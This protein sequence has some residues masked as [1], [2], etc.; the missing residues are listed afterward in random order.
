M[1]H[2]SVQRDCDDLSSDGAMNRRTTSR[3]GLAAIVVACLVLIALTWFGTF[4]AV[5]GQQSAAEARVE[6]GVA[7]QATLFAQQVRVSLAEVDEELRTLAHAWESD[8]D[9]FRLQPWRNQFV[10][11]SEISPDVMLADR[12]GR[13]IDGTARD[14]I[15]SDVADQD[16]FRALSRRPLDDGSM[17]VGPST[18]SR[19]MPSWH[20]NLARPLRNRDGSFAG[21]VVAMLQISALGSFYNVGDI[22]SHGLVAVVGMEQGVL[23]FIMGHSRA[24]PGT[25]IADSDMFKAMQSSPA[26]VWVGRTTL[27]GIER[28]HG[29]R[30]IAGQGLGV[31][32]AVDRADAMSATKAWADDA[33]MFAGGITLLLLLLA[34]T[35]IYA[36]RAAR[37]REA[38]LDHERRVL[39]GANAELALAKARADART[40]LLQATF[41]GM[42]DGVAMTDA[43]MQLVAWNDRFPEIASVPKDLLRIGLPMEDILHAQAAAGVFGPVDV[44]AEVAR[45]MDIL[46]S[47]TYPRTIERMAPDGRVVELRRN[48]LPDGGFVTLYSDI[49]AH[50]ESVNALRQANALAAAATKAMSRFVAIVSHEIRT[51]LGA[52]LNSLHL[53]AD[54]EM[55]GSHRVLAETAQRAGEALSALINDILEMSRMEAGQ[56]ALRP[57]AFALRPLIESAME[58]FSAQAAR[59]RMAL[60]LSIARGVPTE[61]YED[62]GRL[63][64]I[65]INLLSNALK[66]ADPGEV[67]VI[68][69]V[70]PNGAEPRLRLAVRDRGPVIP[71]A[72]CIHLFEPFY[73]LQDAKDAASSAGTGLGLTICRHLVA[74]M[75]GEIG[76][77]AWQLGSRDAGNE[78]WLILPIKPMPIGAATVSSRPVAAQPRWL[79]RTRILLVEDILANQMVTATL[80]RR[81]GHQVDVAGNGQEAVGAVATSPYDLVLMDIFMPGMS[82]LEAARQIRALGGPAAS[83]PIVALTANICAEDQAACAAAGMNDMLA[84]P[85]TLR[86]LLDTIARYVWPHR[87]GRL[88]GAREGWPADP[89]IAPVLAPSRLA[90]L[91]ATLPPGTLA[92][93]IETCLADLSDRLASLREASEQRNREGV[94]SATH[95]MAGMAAEYGM[96]SLES[97]LRALMQ[98]DC[99]EATSAA[100]LIDDVAAELRRTA[101]ALQ[102]ALGTELV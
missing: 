29:F 57:G 34:A 67:R 25:S 43:Y 15:G 11:L 54:G 98:S 46:R 99:H 82:G 58:I 62:P 23:R 36:V 77:R 8:P 10:L 17:F 19:L 78:F 66:F 96:A 71:P 7:G 87:S 44:E 14:A 59:C 92:S 60:R 12:R 89:V 13:I 81:E 88:P 20:M 102:E 53:L 63:R 100:P 40:D 97:R 42:S 83:L 64:Q 94:R 90:E 101:A 37:R 70:L 75:G 1:G 4:S 3:F 35:L 48:G 56:L 24:D 95:A 5:H 85:A 30:Q 86:D 74:L 38:A 79:P 28:V 72:S 16:Y 61:L 31:I 39:A 18:T 33:Y 47:G 26:S 65:L 32:V 91:Q 52:L 2:R 27:D 41:A 68:A 51:P 69:E 22:G 80:L 84:K 49:T 21:V 76:C 93:L 6:T 73:K 50:R 45:R 9:H 55:A